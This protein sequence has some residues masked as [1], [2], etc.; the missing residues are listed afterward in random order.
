MS[1][2]QLRA[3]LKACGKGVGGVRST[4][5]CSLIRHYGTPVDLAAGEEEDKS[6]PAA[7]A[8]ADTDA[9]SGAAEEVPLGG[10]Q[11]WSS[12][13]A[14]KTFVH[15]LGLL[16]YSVDLLKSIL[17]FK[18]LKVGGRKAELVERIWKFVR[19]GKVG[20]SGGGASGDESA[21][22]EGS[23]EEEDS[24][25]EEP[26]EHTDVT[27]GSGRKKRTVRWNRVHNVTDD[28]RQGFRQN[29]TMGGAAPEGLSTWRE[30]DMFIH[31]T[32]NQLN[33]LREMCT[34]SN[35]YMPLSYEK[36]EFGEFMAC[37]GINYMSCTISGGLD[38]LF[39]T[40]MRNGDVLPPPAFG[41]R[42]GISRK[43]F[44]LWRKHFRLIM[45]K[46]EDT[47]AWRSCRK[48]WERINEQRPKQIIPGWRINYDESMSAWKGKSAK[49][50]TIYQKGVC[51]NQQHVPRKPEPTG[52]E[53]VTM[54]DAQTFIMLGVDWCEGKHVMKTKAF[55]DKHSHTVA[56]AL[57]LAKPIFN[58]GRLHGGDSWFSGVRA[59]AAHREV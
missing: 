29:A 48:F 2:Q 4:L 20:V 16:K 24:E 13:K 45:T 3:C 34:A 10:E 33:G 21:D 14:T 46:V 43:R 36:F 53:A 54:V 37:M 57:R 17:R 28:L 40:S 59:A 52:C 49:G 19:L 9:D 30:L 38:E 41:V 58:Q 44:S 31:L 27:S 42:F 6:K 15:R 32:P 8:D 55:R 25:E 23:E 7:D 47:D 22:E 50:A 12:S 39:R 18:K 1:N 35:F 11:F 51:P 26:P 5:I 56:T